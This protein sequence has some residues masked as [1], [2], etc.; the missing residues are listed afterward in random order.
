MYEDLDFEIGLTPV[1]AP[2]FYGDYYGQHSSG[3]IYDVLP[4][5]GNIVQ[6]WTHE[7]RC[8]TFCLALQRYG[9]PY[10]LQIFEV[11]NSEVKLVGKNLYFDKVQGIEI[12][13]SSQ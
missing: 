9:L 11:R 10:A 4:L 7:Y 8:V 2:E 5:G 6:F 13:A 12:V 1:I 3:N